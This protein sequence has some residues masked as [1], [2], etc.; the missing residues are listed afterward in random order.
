VLEKGAQKFKL[1]TGNPGI[2][3]GGHTD[4]VGN[5][6]SNQKLSESRAQAVRFILVNNGVNPKAFTTRGYGS[7]KPKT[8]NTTEEGKFQNRRIEYT[9][10]SK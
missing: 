7:K 3:I 8:A 4:N 10:T 2:E 5:N 6:A 9:V 1:L